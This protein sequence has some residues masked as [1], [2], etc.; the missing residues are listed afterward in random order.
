[1]NKEDPEEQLEDHVEDDNLDEDVDED[2]L[3]N[4]G[5]LIVRDDESIT[6]DNLD[7]F[8]QGAQQYKSE[9]EYESANEYDKPIVNPIEGLVEDRRPRMVR[10]LDSDLG[11]G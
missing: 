10:E 3:V 6:N 1:M 2:A 11:R 5:V 8:G 9:D 4:E 7:M